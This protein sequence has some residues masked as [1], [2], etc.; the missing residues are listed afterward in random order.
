LRLF[1]VDL[2]RPDEGARQSGRV[3]ADGLIQSA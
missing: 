3:H 1:D 2:P